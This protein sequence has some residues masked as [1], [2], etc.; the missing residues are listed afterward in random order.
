M[1][2]KGAVGEGRSRLVVVDEL[3][4]TTPLDPYLGLRAL[5]SYSGCSVRWL[6]ERL[7]DPAHPLSCYRVGGKLLVRVSEF[8]A[9]MAAQREQ[10]E[11]RLRQTVAAMLERLRKRA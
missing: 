6:R 7:A 8:D 10:R 1:P 11:P 3:A 4:V 2:A 5:A 9:W